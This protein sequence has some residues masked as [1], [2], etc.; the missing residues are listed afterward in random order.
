MIAYFAGLYCTGHDVNLVMADCPF[1][2]LCA[3]IRLESNINLN[4]YLLTPKLCLN[5]KASK[6]PPGQRP[7][8]PCWR[9]DTG[10]L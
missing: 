9:V 4:L 1:S 3:S 7:T 8:R 2:N 6:K 10:I 5:L